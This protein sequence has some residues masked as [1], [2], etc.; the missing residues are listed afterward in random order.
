MKRGFNISLAACALLLALSCNNNRAYSDMLEAQKRAIN[1]LIDENGYEILKNYP[2]NGTFND[3]QFVILPNG[4]Y[5]NVVDSGNGTRA[6]TG[7]TSVFCRFYVQS[8]I[9]WQYMDTT[10]V[11]CFQNGT[12]PIVY[13]YGNTSPTINN[14]S[15]S[16][17]STLLFSGLEYVGDSSEVRLIIPFH[18]TD[19]NQTFKS[20]G[21]PLFFSKVRYWFEPK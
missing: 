5:M 4:V 1:R 10:T 12:D 3:N 14:N 17:F 18:L 20:A 16:F 8:L 21:V 6:T 13:K 9:E 15:A 2:D 19:N 11:D 7:S